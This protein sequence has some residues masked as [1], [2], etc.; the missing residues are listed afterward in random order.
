MSAKDYVL[1]KQQI[2]SHLLVIGA[3]GVDPPVEPKTADQKN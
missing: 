2:E 3:T 1:L